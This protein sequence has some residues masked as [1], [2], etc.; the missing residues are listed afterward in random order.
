MVNSFFETVIGTRAGK[1][2]PVDKA[3]PLQRFLL[4]WQTRHLFSF[5]CVISLSWS[6][7]SVIV[8][9]QSVRE[10]N[11]L[12]ALV[13]Y[14][15]L[16]RK[17]WKLRPT[18][19]HLSKMH[20]DLSRSS[21]VKLWSSIVSNLHR[22]YRRVRIFVVECFLLDISRRPYFFRDLVKC[23]HCP[24]VTPKCEVSNQQFL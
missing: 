1:R 11:V 20:T 23:L 9:D 18:R 21:P 15:W 16:R 22:K 2:K 6:I 4:G 10:M 19:I 17:T 3:Q 12:L 8:K 14:G 7:K 24:K 13:N 5:L